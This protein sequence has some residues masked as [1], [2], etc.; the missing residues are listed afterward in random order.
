MLPRATRSTERGGG[1][2]ARGGRRGCRST[3][4][5]ST[6]CAPT[7]L[8]RRQPDRGPPQSALDDAPP[9]AVRADQVAADCGEGGQ[10]GQ[11]DLTR[12]GVVSIEIG[13]AAGG[14][15]VANPLR[16]RRRVNWESTGMARHRA[17]SGHDELSTM[18]W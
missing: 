10:G 15:L 17:Q 11:G 4:S 18:S 3:I 2:G 16:F 9:G 1:L 12:L 7:G 8:P 5:C 14:C 13:D 6:H